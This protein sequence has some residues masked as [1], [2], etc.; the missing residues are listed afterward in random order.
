MPLI[1]L[2]LDIISFTAF[3]GGLKLNFSFSS[4]FTVKNRPY[5]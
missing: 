3:L 2:R 1:N 4:D 5:H